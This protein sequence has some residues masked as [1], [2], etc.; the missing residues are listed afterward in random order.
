[1]EQLLRNPGDFETVEIARLEQITSA[2]ETVRVAPLVRPPPEPTERLVGRRRR[3]LP[4]R[5]RWQQV[6]LLVAALLLLVSPL[7][8]E[9]P[10]RAEAS[11][12]PA[13]ASLADSPATSVSAAP[14]ATRCRLEVTSRPRNALVWIDDEVIGDTPLAAEVDCA[15]GLLAIEKNRYRTEVRTLSFAERSEVT[16]DVSLEKKRRR[17]Q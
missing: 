3:G 14:V 8:R 16:I 12:P 2:S 5:E 11:P 7:G 1:M 17:R 4:W 6:Q 15:G 9:E 13:A 10:A